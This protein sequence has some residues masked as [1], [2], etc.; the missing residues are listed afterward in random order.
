MTDDTLLFHDPAIDPLFPEPVPQIR[1]TVTCGRPFP[2]GTWFR[3]D[4]IHT[5]PPTLFHHSAPATYPDPERVGRYIRA[6]IHDH[7]LQL[8]RM[9]RARGWVCQLCDLAA[10]TWVF[11]PKMLLAS[12]G[13]GPT[14]FAPHLWYMVVP[15]CRKGGACNVWAE[16]TLRQFWGETAWDNGLAWEYLER[17]CCGKCSLVIAHEI[18][19]QHCGLPCALFLPLHV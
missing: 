14:H 5:P 17:G 12:G 3:D 16:Q 4:S 18:S 6:L 13:S 2:E 10:N 15:I 7:P 19:C 9:I 11:R 1:F 8:G